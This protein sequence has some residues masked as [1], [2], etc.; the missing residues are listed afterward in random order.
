VSGYLQNR[1]NLLEQFAG[2]KVSLCQV[3]VS[4]CYSGYVLVVKDLGQVPSPVDVLGIDDVNIS[5]CH[6]SLCQILKLH[7]P[8]C[9]PYVSL[10]FDGC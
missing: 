5:H 1:F 8:E 7:S 3:L 4:L 2:V 6:H 9:Y 10:S